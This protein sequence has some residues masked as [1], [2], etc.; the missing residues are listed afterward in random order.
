MVLLHISIT[1]TARMLLL[2]VPNGP[3]GALLSSPFHSIG[4]D[5]PG[6]PNDSLLQPSLHS[7]ASSVASKSSR[8]AEVVLHERLLDWA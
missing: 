5:R 7:F 6:L 4:P 3:S 8:A 2:A 1:S